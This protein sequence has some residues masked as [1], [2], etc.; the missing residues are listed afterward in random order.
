[1]NN[2]LTFF[3][4]FKF[5]FYLFSCFFF[6]SQS[7]SFYYLPFSFKPFS[8]PSSYSSRS[9]FFMVFFFS[10]FGFFLFFFLIFFSNNYSLFYSFL[11]YFRKSF[12]WS[13]SSLSIYLAYV[14]LCIHPFIKSIYPHH[15]FSYVHCV[16]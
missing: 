4:F 3:L 9:P 8:F 5:V 11:F 2:I 7:S 16:F 1:M 13:L 15:S 6:F 12:V 10:F 14:F